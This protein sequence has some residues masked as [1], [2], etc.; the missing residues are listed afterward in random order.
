MVRPLGS[1]RIEIVYLEITLD[2]VP[3]DGLAAP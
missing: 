1:R 2:V 3:K